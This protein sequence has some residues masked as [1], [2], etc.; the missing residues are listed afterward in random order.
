MRACAGGLGDVP[1]PEPNLLAVAGVVWLDH[2]RPWLLPGGRWVH[3]L[4][5]W[6]PVLA[7]V[8]LIWRSW[9]E[10]SEV[11]LDRPAHLVTSGPYAASRNPMYLGW[12]LLQL[13]AGVVR[14]SG[15]TI[16]AV[17]AA[18]LVHREVRREERAL[19]D[20]FGAPTGEIP[21]IEV[22]SSVSLS[23]SSTASCGSRCRRDAGGRRASR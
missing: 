9:A 10:A 17:S 6:P 8:R 11:E 18:L 1:L 22:T 7:G 19:D 3:H 12:A 2:T 16:V 13:G 4:A 15:W 21:V 20:A 14:G 23:S 5:G